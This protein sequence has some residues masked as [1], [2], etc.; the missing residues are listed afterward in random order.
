LHFAHFGK[1]FAA[2]IATTI[3]R[4]HRRPFDTT[5]SLI[6]YRHNGSQGKQPH[7]EEPYDHAIPLLEER[8]IETA[9]KSDSLSTDFRKDWQRRVRVHFDQVIP[10]SP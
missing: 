9:A 7:L 2:T 1:G 8:H 10:L 6:K 3:E 5:R 4:R